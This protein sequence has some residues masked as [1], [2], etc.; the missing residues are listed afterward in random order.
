MKLKSI[1]PFGALCA[2]LLASL[3][4]GPLSAE[5]NGNQP[6]PLSETIDVTVVNVEAVVTDRSGIRI[7]DLQKSD[8]RL[9]VDGVETPIEYFSEVL[10][11]DVVDRNENGPEANGLVAG[12]PLG[13][14]YLVFVDEFFT[15]ASDRRRVLRSLIDELDFLGPE[16]RM[17]VVAWD[18]QRIDMLS[19]WSQSPRELSEVLRQAAERPSGGLNRLSELRQFEYGHEHLYRRE[20]YRRNDFSSFDA[21]RL[22]VEE[23]AYFNLLHRQLEGAVTATTATL[24]GFA[25]PPGRKVMLAL[26]G[27]WPERPADYVVGNQARVPIDFINTGGSYLY[28]PL[29]ETANLLGYT[30]YPVDVHGLEGTSS[31]VSA[32]AAAQRVSRSRNFDRELSVH[33]GLEHLAEETGGIAL[34]NGMRDGAF[35]RVFEDTRTFYWIGFSP[36]RSGDDSQHEIRLEVARKGLKLRSRTGYVDRSR[37]AE[38]TMAVESAL[39]FGGPTSARELEVLVGAVQKAGFGRI[40]VPLTVVLPSDLLTFLPDGDEWVG[41]LELRVAAMDDRG[42]RADVPV[43]PIEVRQSSQPNADDTF[44]YETTLKMR[45]RDHQMVVGLLDESSGELFSTGAAIVR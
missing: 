6:T 43:I 41:R 1:Y 22:D 34:L 20:L 19:S 18:G 26:A 10:G 23:R 30:L 42:H 9:L 33:Y 3:F 32:A 31:A 25:M 27:T 45:P 28:G 4:A 24:R 40:E 44:S 14:S 8:F 11:G 36:E 38:A 35:G 37:G 5:S 12:T 39:L 16:D 21:Q 17:A 2:L 7:P 15:L 29:T 13:T